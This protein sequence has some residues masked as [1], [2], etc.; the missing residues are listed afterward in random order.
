MSA[1]SSRRRQRPRPD[2]AIPQ[3][4]AETRTRPL[5][6]LLPALFLA[7]LVAYQPVWRGGLLWD[8]GGHLTRAGLRSTTGL[9]RIWFDLGATQQYYP[10]AHS[11]FWL[12]HRLWGDDTLGYHLVNISLHALS[13][14]LVAV[15]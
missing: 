8:D 5:W 13:A 11:A 7:V 15:L 10:M 4:A 6:P 9:W 14:F 1:R 12:F 2:A 3:T